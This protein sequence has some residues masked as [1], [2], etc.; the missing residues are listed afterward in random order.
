[1]GK[2]DAVHS[3]GERLLHHPG[4]GADRRLVEARHGQRDDHGRCAVS[5]RPGTTVDQS[6][7]ELI[8]P[9]DVEGAVF[10]LIFDI[11]GPGAGQ[12][13]S[14]LVAAN[15]SHVEDRLVLLEQLDRLVHSLRRVWRRLA[16]CVR[17]FRGCDGE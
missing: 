15:G 11:V 5:A 9:G 1:M 16:G 2:D 17:G 13:P 4:V 3:R 14:F 6:A 8:Q 12:P 7:H 10:R